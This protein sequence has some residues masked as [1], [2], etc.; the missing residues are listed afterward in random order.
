MSDDRPSRGFR[1]TPFKLF[2]AL[3][4]TL[5]PIGAIII[6]ATIAELNDR[7]D[8]LRGQTQAEMLVAARA[9]EGLIGRNVLALR[10]AAYGAIATDGQNPCDE[11]RAAL[12]VAP[13]VARDFRISTADNNQLCGDLVP[14]GVRPG[15]PVGPGE[16]SLWIN[17]EEDGLYLSIGI[18]EAIATGRISRAELIEAID[19]EAEM[20]DLFLL[21]DGTR[22]LSLLS[23]DNVGEGERQT[24]T[25]EIDIARGRLTAEASGSFVDITLRDRLMIFL[26]LAMW[27]IAAIL[28]WALIHFVLMR[29]LR[30]LNSAVR[31]YDIDS[32]DFVPPDK[33]G[34]AAEIRE[35]GQSFS[36][37]VDRIEAGERELVEA[38]ENQRKLVREVHHRVKNNL[39][40]VASLLN[41]HSRGA[42]GEEAQAAYAGIGRRVEA[43]SVVHRNHFAE[44]EESRGIQLR[45]LIT[46]LSTSLRASAPGGRQVDFALDLESAATTQDAAV[47]AAFFITEIV[48][49]AFNRGD[50][51]AVEIGLRRTS[52]LTARLSV[53]SEAL[54]GDEGDP[55]GHVQF[56]RIIDGLSRQLRSPL[57]KKLGSYAV[58]LPVFPH[59]D[60]A[61]PA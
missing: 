12:S 14:S 20:V 45:P 29:P 57:D 60:S 19:A 34:P 47:S 61:R 54:I 8:A 42:E 39:Q 35:L 6:W 16:V 15:Q 28:S 51:E 48:E 10:I 37:T 38:V 27:A 22:T 2:L 36:D 3:T 56:E 21:R 9:I 13:A 31:D 55:G 40:V 32:H 5:L 25:L 1:S 23:E 58:E 59:D 18:P 41:I 52:E 30:R 17:R 44:I 26:P 33:L 53:A 43:L 50:C 24:E 11:A 46:E 4:L 49:H 7:R